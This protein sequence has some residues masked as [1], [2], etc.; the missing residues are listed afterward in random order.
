ME[1]EN[2]SKKDNL[3]N[4]MCYIPVVS[5]IFFFIESNRSDEFNKH[6]KYGIFL[7]IAYIIL[8]FFLWWAFWWLLALVYLWISWFLW[9]KAYNWENIELEVFDTLEKTVKEKMNEKNKT[10]WGNSSMEDPLGEKNDDNNK[11]EL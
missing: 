8:M 6:I 4:A 2:G 1:Q 11:N 10:N 5:V 3:K 9:Y 7:L